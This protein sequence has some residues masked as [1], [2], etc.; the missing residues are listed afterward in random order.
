M[1]LCL[2]NS[3][4]AHTNDPN[5]PQ[6]KFI[7]Y[8]ANTLHY[9]TSSLLWKNFF[10]RWQSMEN[11]YQGNIN[12]VQI[13]GSHVQAGTLPNTIRR[14][15]ITTY[16]NLVASRGMI[17]PYSA[18]ARCNNPPD[19]RVNCPQ[20]M[21]LTRNVNRDISYPLG[22]CGIAITATDELKE[23]KITLNEFQQFYATNKIIILG[24][25]NNK[26]VPLLRV[27]NRDVYPSYIDTET[28]R[29]VFNLSQIVD[30]FVVV[31]PCT[32]SDTFTLTGIYLGN[33]HSGFSFHS[34]GVNGAAVVDY[35]KCHHFVRDLRLLHP[36]LVIFGIGIND[37]TANPFDT[38]AF[39]LKYLQLVDSVRRVNP[40]CAILFITNNDSF[41]RVGRKKYRVN[42]NGALA[43]EAFYRIAKECDGAVWDQ[44]EVMGGLKSMEQWTAAHLG[45][46]DRIHFT[47]SGYE[48]LG[49]MLFEALTSA[50][51]ESLRSQHISDNTIKIQQ[52]IP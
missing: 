23:M 47:R 38:T 21:I 4:F 37:A 2:G 14:N 35:L 46:R 11:T 20:R 6:H 45:Q 13:G 42:A 51:H 52:R 5:P 33:Q 36:D 39:R 9:D 12:I 48:L 19:Y 32:T 24:K 40:D 7:N 50:Y 43:R 41:K 27:N 31:I 16:P 22:L 26:V 18:A 10:S 17:F 8:N 3:V 1:L 34:I 29:H 15:F 25:S 30:S 28:D 49:N 44:F